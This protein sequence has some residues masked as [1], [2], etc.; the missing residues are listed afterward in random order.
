MKHRNLPYSAVGFLK[1]YR[2]SKWVSCHHRLTKFHEQ[3]SFIKYVYHRDS[4]AD[5]D[6]RQEI[7]KA[8]FGHQ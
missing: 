2:N 6:Y 8:K 4:H 5:K 3:E 7:F 1:Y